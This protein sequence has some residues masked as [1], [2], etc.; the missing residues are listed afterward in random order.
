MV[1]DYVVVISSGSHLGKLSD[2]I[3]EWW[4]IW[5]ARSD[6]VDTV[7]FEPMR[8]PGPNPSI[9][10]YSLARLLWRDEALDILCR[11]GL[12]SGVSNMPRR[13]LWSRL[14]ETIE[15]EELS[16][17]VRQTLKTREG[18]RVPHQQR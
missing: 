7:V 3:P 17:I 6:G 9:D 10:P 15:L 4:G 14:A 8:E 12:D 11:R 2:L 1:L 16:E 5:E 13:H 18:W